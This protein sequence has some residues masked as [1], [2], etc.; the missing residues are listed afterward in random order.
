MAALTEEN[1]EHVVKEVLLKTLPNEPV[2]Y[3]SKAWGDFSKF[4]GKVACLHL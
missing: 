3:F 4:L 1:V 2:I